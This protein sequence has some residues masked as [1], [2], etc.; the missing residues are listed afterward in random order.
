[1]TFNDIQSNLFEQE[2]YVTYKSLTSDKTHKV[3][4]TIPRKFQRD[5][6]K[7]LLWSLDE[8]KWIDVEVTTVVDI[9]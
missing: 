7:V 3:L 2:R 4:C 8:D 5:S 9:T 6:D 1:M